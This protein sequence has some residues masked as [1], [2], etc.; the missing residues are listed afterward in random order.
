MAVVTAASTVVSAASPVVVGQAYVSWALFEAYAGLTH[1]NE[2][3][4]GTDSGLRTSVGGTTVTGSDA[5]LG[6]DVGLTATGGALSKQGLEF[7]FGFSRTAA[8]GLVYAFRDGDKRAVVQQVVGD[9]SKAGAD[10]GGGADASG[11]AADQQKAVNDVGHYVEVSALDTH[12]VAAPAQV[13]T[14]LIDFSWT[15]EPLN[16]VPVWQDA[17]AY[18]RAWNSKRG[19]SYEYD[20]MEAGGAAYLLSNRDKRFDPTNGSSPYSPNVIPTRRVRIQADYAGTVYPVIEAFTDGFPQQYPGVGMDAVVR[21]SASDWFYPLNTLKFAGGETVLAAPITDTTQTVVAVASTALPL[22]QAYPFIIQ[23]GTAPDIERMEVTGSPA[24]GQWAVERGAGDTAL[25]IYAAGTPVRSEAVRFGR[26]LSGTRINHCL[27]FLGVAGPDRDIDAGNTTIAASDD[28]VNTRILEHLLLIAECE[29]GR[30]FVARDG[31]V[32]FRER[33]WQ[34]L[35]E[36]APRATFGT[37]GTIPYLGEGVELAHDDAKLYNRVKI[38]IADGTVVEA[39]DQ[40]SIDDH[41]ER[42]LEKSWPLASAVEAQDAAAW[43]LTRLK[44]AQL[45]VPAITV[46]VSGSYTPAVLGAEI[47]QRYH[48]VVDP[49]VAGGVMSSDV[50]VE[51]IAHTVQPGQWR[52]TYELS[53][54]DPVKYWRVEVAGAS[55]LGTTTVLAY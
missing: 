35:Q 55:E 11:L 25:R 37:G 42:T 3:A 14:P 31:A 45:R 7:G 23:V 30:L 50:I 13:L 17:S 39:A 1:G 34:F 18:L 51:G 53:E 4:T 28:L 33:H 8:A 52:T 2:A 44:R 29:N 24:P 10:T 41:M 15:T 32:T 22:P 9:Q 19:R 47:A 27:D 48:L 16:P 49:P 20:R 12:P 43:M 5:G 36:L 21:Q 6:I 40:A 38:T 26:E 46:A 54:P